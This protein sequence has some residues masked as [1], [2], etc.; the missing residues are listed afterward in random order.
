MRVA[1]V[2]ARPGRRVFVFSLGFHEDF[3]LRRLHSHGASGGD[4][5]VAVT[6]DPVVGGV[7]RAFESIRTMASRLGLAEPVLLRVP[8]GDL[9]RAVAMV[10]G[11]VRSG[12]GYV[13]ADVTGGPRFAGLAVL[14]GVV[15]SGVDGE[16]WV[17]SEAGGGW[18]ARVPLGVLRLLRQPL[19]P[20]KR[21]LLEFF[22][23]NPGCRPEDAAAELGVAPKT[24]LNHL[25]ELK[26]LGLV[27]QRGRGG[28]VYVT[29]WG[30]ALTL[31]GAGTAGG[32]SSR[33]TSRG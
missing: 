27:A 19:S 2:E 31:G 15:F 6:L 12:G 17:Q 28:G 22:A 5:I 29:E 8:G 30:A 25:S 32:T 16:V 3:A 21:R 20:E 26:R 9:A 23:A 33:G 14:L 13:V 4:R 1:A 24:V 7:A 18:E 10:A 11:A